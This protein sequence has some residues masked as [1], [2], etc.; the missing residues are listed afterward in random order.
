MMTLGS[1]SA[2]RPTPATRAVGAS[3]CQLCGS[4]E[5]VVLSNR[6]RHGKPL[7]TVICLQCGLVWSDPLPHNPR[8]FYAQHYRLHYK[9]TYTPKPKHILRAGRLALARYQ[10]IRHLLPTP[11]TVL[12]VG[13]GGGEFIYLLHKLGHTVHGVEPNQGYAAYARSEYGLHVHIGFAQDVALP[14]E[15]FD[16]IT[17]WHVLEHTE[18]PD[19]VLLKLHR[20]LKP[21]GMLVI[22]VPNVEATCQAPQNTFHEAHIFNFN[23]PTLQKLAE[24]T[25]FTGIGQLTSDDGGNITL[26]ARKSAEEKSGTPEA[27]AIPGNAERIIRTVRGHTLLKHYATAHPYRRLW[28]RLRQYLAEQHGIRGFVSGRLL[29][30]RLYAPTLSQY[31]HPRTPYQE[32]ACQTSPMTRAGM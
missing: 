15:H 11:R 8:E 24:K 20:R 10:T 9:G 6:G 7:R 23:L 25:G 31:A 22:E 32:P 30:D 19:E 13:S 17:M 4:P 29:L 5:S 2:T 26:F 14:E 18:R 3:P 1:P 28:H 12:D 16:L 27:L 21:E